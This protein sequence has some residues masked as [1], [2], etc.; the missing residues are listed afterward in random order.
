MVPENDF[1]IDSQMPPILEPFGTQNDTNCLP[2]GSSKINQK[3]GTQKFEN[4]AAMG[5]HF[6]PEASPK[7][8]QIMKKVMPERIPAPHRNSDTFFHIC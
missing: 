5:C 2:E 1:R 3:T 6:R 4:G 8:P 7:P